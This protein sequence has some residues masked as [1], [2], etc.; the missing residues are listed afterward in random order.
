MQIRR[1]R[2]CFRGARPVPHTEAHLLGEPDRATRPAKRVSGQVSPAQGRFHCRSAA[3]HRKTQNGLFACREIDCCKRP[4]AQPLSLFA[5]ATTI[6]LDSGA[7][8]EQGGKEGPANKQ[9]VGL[10]ACR[11]ADDWSVP[12]FAE[13]SDRHGQPAP[14]QLLAALSPPQPPRG[15]PL[16][17]TPMDGQRYRWDERLRVSGGW[18]RRR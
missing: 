10:A 16:P 7:E 18:L 12:P 3:Q 11:A 17:Q 15:P 2:W 4:T 6:W 9:N 13:R 5:R 14:L 1:R 8:E